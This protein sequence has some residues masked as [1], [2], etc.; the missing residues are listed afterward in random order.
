M[1][2]II[3]SLAVLSSLFACTEEK[4]VLVEVEKEVEVP[5]LDTLWLPQDTVYV[6]PP[7]AELTAYDLI[8]AGALVVE[9]DYSGDRVGPVP[10]RDLIDEGF[11][12]V[13]LDNGSGEVVPFELNN[14]STGDVFNFNASA[15]KQT[16]T[17]VTRGTYKVFYN[18]K[19]KTITVQ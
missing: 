8:R 4:E 2:K 1:R 12:T 19:Q 6:T 9:A 14:L 5:V 11:V 17:I 3:L 15:N 10:I 13:R 16:F 7:P 18:D